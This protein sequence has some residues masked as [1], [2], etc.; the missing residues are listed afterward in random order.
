[1][2]HV[3]LGEG[4]R[5]VAC[6]KQQRR[7]APAAKAAISGNVGHY[8]SIASSALDVSEGAA[9]RRAPL[10]PANS[11]DQQPHGPLVLDD[12][13]RGR[14]PSARLSV[15]VT[16]RGPPPAQCHPQRALQYLRLLLRRTVEREEY[17][18]RL[19]SRRRMPSPSHALAP[20]RRAAPRRSST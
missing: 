12:V 3:Q 5:V 10:S 17:G 9:R 16:H 1:M 19:A 6:V 18:A 8:P 13:A 14:S 15:C 2:T 11:G 7:I 20:S 4:G